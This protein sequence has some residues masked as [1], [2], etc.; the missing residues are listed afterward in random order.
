MNLGFCFEGEYRV[1]S[2]RSYCPSRLEGRWRG[3]GQ[4]DLDEDVVNAALR[5]DRRWRGERSVSL[6][7]ALVTKRSGA[8][9]EPDILYKKSQ[10]REAPGTPPMN[11]NIVDVRKAVA[12]WKGRAPLL[13]SAIGEDQYRW[14]SDILHPLDRTIANEYFAHEAGHCLGYATETKYSDG[15]FLAAGRTLWPLVYLEELRADLLAF[16]FAAEL[17]PPNEAAAL[18]V[19]NLL[20]RLGAHLE[21]RGQMTHPYGSIPM[22]LWT[23]LARRGAA[24]LGAASSPAFMFSTCDTRSLCSLMAELAADATRWFVEPEMAAGDPLD[25]ALEASNVYRR[26]ASEPTRFEAACLAAGQRNG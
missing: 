24:T 25:A 13:V 16:G 14:A 21:G 15:Y 4:G 22:M 6:R 3:S 7:P 26:L 2:R 1:Q 17:L 19:Y 23:E 8:F 9:L 12:N 20:L 11:R 18:F 10:F 5:R